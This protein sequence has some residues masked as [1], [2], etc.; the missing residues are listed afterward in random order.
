MADPNASTGVQANGADPKN[1]QDLTVFVSILNYLTCNTE[2]LMRNS[3]INFRIPDNC[4]VNVFQ[5]SK[6]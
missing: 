1:V 5:K 3:E 4:E 2:T 6:I